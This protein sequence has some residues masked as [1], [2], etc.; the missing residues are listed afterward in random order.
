MKILNIAGHGFAGRRFSVLSLYPYFKLLKLKQPPFPSMHIF[1][2][3]KADTVAFRSRKL[4]PPPFLYRFS[5]N[6]SR[7]MIFCNQTVIYFGA[8]VYPCL[9]NARVFCILLSSF[10]FIEPFQVPFGASWFWIEIM[11]FGSRLGFKMVY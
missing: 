1:E 10:V 6:P 5:F 2:S 7:Y 8:I 4:T 11:V 3:R 9:A